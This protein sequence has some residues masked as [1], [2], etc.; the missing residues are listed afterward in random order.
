MINGA[1]DFFELAFVL[2]FWVETNGKTVEEI[3][4]LFDGTKHSHVPDLETMILGKADFEIVVNSVE[5]PTAMKSHSET[6]V[7]SKDK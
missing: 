2:L 3:D 7:S 5:A 1:W 4:E 6:V